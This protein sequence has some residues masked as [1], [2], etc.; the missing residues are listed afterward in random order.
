M[1]A[2]SYFQGIMV[3]VLGILVGHACLIYVDDV[4]VLGR[5]V[6]E[7]IANLRAVLLRFMERGL[8]LAAHKLI[9]FAKEVRWCG[10]VYSGSSVRHDP[11]RVRGLVEMRRPATVGELM[12]FLQA[13]N[14]MRLSLPNM[15]EVVA[16]LRALMELKLQ[17]T[18]R[19]KRVASRRA[20]VVDDWTPEREAAWEVSRE[21][22]MHSEE[23]S[24]WRPEACRVLMFPDASDLFWGCCLTQVPK[25]ELVQDLGVVDMSHEPL[26][27]LSGAFRGSQ[28]CW[29]TV[30]K[31]SFAILSAFQRVP[32][33]LWEGSEIFCD[34]RNLAYIFSPQSCGVT[35]GKAA[36]QRL[37]GWRACMSQFPYVIQHIHPGD[38]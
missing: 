23:L 33:L 18:N 12:Q 17:G 26:A 31:E 29:P 5:T 9:L 30:D 20:L 4:K 15:A 32:Y 14:W 3:E 10:K 8:F 11:E 36:S 13:A 1:N 34:H 37:A 6:E 25:E 19:T 38:R 24:F 22:L 7:L 16:P 2:T 21:M 27:F 28:L 35:L